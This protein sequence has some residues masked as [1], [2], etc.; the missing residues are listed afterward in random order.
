MEIRAASDAKQTASHAP[1]IDV[2]QQ[3]HSAPACAE[4]A[5]IH[6]FDQSSVDCDGKAASIG[7]CTSRNSALKRGKEI[8]NATGKSSDENDKEVSSSPKIVNGT[9]KPEPNS[10]NSIHAMDRTASR[11]N[12]V[13]PPELNA[14]ETL[15]STEKTNICIS[16]D[17]N[18]LPE[19]QQGMNLQRKRKHGK[20]CLQEA[21]ITQAGT[22]SVSTKS[23]NIANSATDSHR[24]VGDDPTDCQRF[25]SLTA[26]FNSENPTPPENQ[27]EPS[28]ASEA[29]GTKDQEVLKGRNG[30]SKKARL[31]EAGKVPSV[32]RSSREVPCGE[33][34]YNTRFKGVIKKEATKM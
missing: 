12:R 10:S 1:Q 26:S 17:I 2:K 9:I 7:S 13:A 24:S 29:N 3:R 23:I 18:S 20:D 27:S 19:C 6:T 32:A 5:R 11:R 30:C 25:T 14:H 4:S 28:N 8:A 16:K 31:L 33:R 15:Q 22:D 34:R 21:A